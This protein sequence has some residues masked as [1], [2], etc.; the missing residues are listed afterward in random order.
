MK[1]II[2]SRPKPPEPAPVIDEPMIGQHGHWV[3]DP[4]HSHGIW[5]PGHTH[6]VSDPGHSHG[7]YDP[8]MFLVALNAARISAASAKRIRLLNTSR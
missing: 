6:G 5:D 4:G 2:H 7:V 1:K 8:E 3:I